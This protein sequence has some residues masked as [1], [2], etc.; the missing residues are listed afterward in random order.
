[1]RKISLLK[2]AKQEAKAFFRGVLIKRPTE[3]QEYRKM[4]N[5]KKAKNEKL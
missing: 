1:M 2:I 5:L 4:I 3:L